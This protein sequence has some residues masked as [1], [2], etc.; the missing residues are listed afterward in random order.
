MSRRLRVFAATARLSYE[1]GYSSVT[2]ADITA[3]AQVSRSAFY[4]QFRDKAEAA[5]QTTEFKFE[6]I[7][8]ACAEAY[9]SASQWPDRVWEAARAFA[10]YFTT[11]A[12]YAYTGIVEPHAIGDE[13]IQYVYD[14][15][16]AFGLFLEE[17]YRWRSQV[18]GLPRVFSEAIGATMFEIGFRALRERRQSDWYA[19]LLPQFVFICLAPFMTPDGAT[20]FIQAKLAA[21]AGH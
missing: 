5:T 18:G 2:V 3:A 10:G 21:D 17:G 14:R 7:I 11:C 19:M 12:D 4:R 13:A 1:T 8:G 16:G 9:S 20:E 6:Q 15:V